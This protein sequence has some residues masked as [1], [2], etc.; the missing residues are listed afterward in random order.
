MGKRIISQ[1]RGRGTFTYKAHSHRHKGKISNYGKNDHV[2]G[3]V[4]DIIHNPGHNAPCALV[5]YE[6]EIL[7]LTQEIVLDILEII[8]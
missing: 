3:E 5:K 8:K 4:I 6:N 2:K 1:R 7:Y